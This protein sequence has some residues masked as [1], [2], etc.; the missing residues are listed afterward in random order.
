MNGKGILVVV[1]GFA[2][3]GKGTVMKKLLSNYNEYSLS[4]SA[5]T[6]APRPGEVNGNE[7]FFKTKDEFEE[8]IDKGELIEHAR[9]VNNYY[10][11]PKKYVRDQLDLG[12][13]VILEIEIQGALQI[14]SK[15]PDTLLLFL[16]PPNVEILKNRLICRGTEDIA[17][18]QARLTRACEEVAFIDKYDYIL[19]NNEIEECVSKVHSIIQN[20]HHRIFRNSD[21]LE[22]I[23][24]DF[25]LFLKGE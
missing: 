17:T 16:T 1:S 21:F 10:G 24:E 18:I 2:G 3:S 14:K 8:M 22:N 7:Y 11:T 25:E 23:K 12:K 13:D 9:Y 19:V 6:R 4:I 5:T 15:Y 20:E